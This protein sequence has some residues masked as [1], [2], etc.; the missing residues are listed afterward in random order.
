MRLIRSLASGCVVLLGAV[1]PEDNCLANDG[2]G[3]DIREVQMAARMDNFLFHIPAGPLKSAL[4][5]WA[6]VTGQRFSIS[7]AAA[8]L[9]S[10]SVDGYFSAEGALRKLL[11]GTGK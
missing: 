1:A 6:G 3:E 9:Q 5:Q 4:T 2:P 7:S 10:T 8:N 11:E